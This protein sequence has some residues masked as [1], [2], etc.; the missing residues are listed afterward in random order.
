MWIDV[1]G[2]LFVSY[3]DED[4]VF[5]DGVVEAVE[6]Y[7]VNFVFISFFKFTESENTR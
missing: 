4:G 3:F 6:V 7:K 5:V 1:A 2:V